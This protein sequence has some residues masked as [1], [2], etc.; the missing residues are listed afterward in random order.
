MHSGRVPTGLQGLRG[1]G[2]RTDLLLAPTGS[3][4]AV[5][6]CYTYNLLPGCQGR[7]THGASR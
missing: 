3:R 2:W 6:T 4:V 5:E 7:L 1:P